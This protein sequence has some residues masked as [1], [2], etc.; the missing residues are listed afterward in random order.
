MTL[1]QDLMAAAVLVMFPTSEGRTA[2]TWTYSVVDLPEDVV[3]PA[4][5]DK[6][7][8]VDLARASK[9]GE[10]VWAEARDVLA[11]NAAIEAITKMAAQDRTLLLATRV[12]VFVHQQVKVLYVRAAQDEAGGLLSEKVCGWQFEDVRPGPVTRMVREELAR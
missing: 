7:Q 2:E 6:E 9:R 1:Y 4:L 8:I 5:A 3:G 12:T 10:D 11:R